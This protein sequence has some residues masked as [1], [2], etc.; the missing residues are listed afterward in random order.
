MISRG[1]YFHPPISTVLGQVTKKW[2]ESIENWYKD[3]VEFYTGVWTLKSA[4][5]LNFQDR[6]S[7]FLDQGGFY[8]S[9]RNHISIQCTKWSCGA[10]KHGSY[11]CTTLFWNSISVGIR[12]PWTRGFIFFMSR[13][14]LSNSRSLKFGIPCSKVKR[15]I[16]SN[17]VVWFIKIISWLFKKNHG[18]SLA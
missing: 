13:I 18:F 1:H 2:I 8:I 6:C 4:M 7:Y 3:R 12:Y 11:I 16:F 5:K 15:N 9:W 14:F 10:G 17:V